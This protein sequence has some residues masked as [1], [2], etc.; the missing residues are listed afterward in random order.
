MLKQGMEQAAIDYHAE[1]TFRTIRNEDTTAELLRTIDKEIESQTQAIILQPKN[2]LIL[3]EKLQKLNDSISIYLVNSIIDMENPF[4]VVATDTYILGQKL[5]DKILSTRLKN[6]PILILKENFNYTETFH[7]YQGITSILDTAFVPYEIREV[8]GKNQEHQLKQLLKKQEYDGVIA[9]TPSMLELV[10]KIK[11]NENKS[12]L[13]IFGFQKTNA[14]LALIDEGTVEAIG[15][16]NQFTVG[17]QAVQQIFT[18][19]IS[20][21]DKNEIQQIIVDKTNLFSEENQKL[22]FPVVQ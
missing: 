12:G 21:L 17:Y 20:Q 13:R 19:K 15:L 7:Y 2:I 6:N 1:L 9:F 16:S 14:T 18:D 11:T 10:G 5:A 3:G 8:K 22:L 4:P